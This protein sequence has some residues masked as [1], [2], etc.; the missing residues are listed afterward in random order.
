MVIIILEV[1]VEELFSIVVENLVV[2]AAWLVHA[3]KH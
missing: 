3:L 2:E 1:L